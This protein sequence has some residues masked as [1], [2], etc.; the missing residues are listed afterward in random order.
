MKLRSQSIL[1]A[2]LSLLL[3]TACGPAPA[4]QPEQA[5]PPQAL[6]GE[7]LRPLTVTDVAIETGPGS[8]GLLQIVASGDWPDWCAQLAQVTSRID[9][10]NIQ[11]ELYATP[12]APAC[13][14]D[15]VG[16][17]FRIPIPLNPV[18]LPAGTYFV[19]VNSFTTSFV[20]QP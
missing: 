13:P 9:G 17:S 6:P 20:W 4:V 16:V 7:T 1:A 2:A 14:P 19:T 3:L 10:M 11:I 8:P 5:A 15:Y 12:A 18:Q